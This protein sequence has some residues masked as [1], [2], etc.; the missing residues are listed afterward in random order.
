M[1]YWLRMLWEEYE[2]GMQGST[3]ERNT[4]SEVC[5]QRKTFVSTLVDVYKVSE[6]AVVTMSMLENERKLVSLKVANEKWKVSQF[7]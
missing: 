6:F 7:V 5:G 1:P 2:S 3:F 4:G